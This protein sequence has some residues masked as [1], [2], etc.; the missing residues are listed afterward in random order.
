MLTSV[1]GIIITRTMQTA[2]GVFGN[3]SSADGGNTDD[4][5][6]IPG[7]LNCPQIMAVELCRD[8]LVWLD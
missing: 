5:S 1:D 6:A 3:E 7:G 2:I 8:R 4:C